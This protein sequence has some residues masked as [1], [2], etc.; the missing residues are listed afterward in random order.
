MEKHIT[1]GRIA[2]YLTG[3]NV[4][5]E[6]K[7]MFGGICFMVDG[8]MLAGANRDNKLLVR[9]DPAEENE[10][11]QRPGDVCIMEHGTRPMH[12]YLYVMPEGYERDADLAFWIEKCL[13]YN[14]RAKASRK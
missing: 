1:S 14:P 6:E 5:F 8:K 7:K 10:L 12:G 3:R 2:D 11:L 4:A 9:V 13:E